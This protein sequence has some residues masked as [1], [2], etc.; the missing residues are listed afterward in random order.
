MEWNLRIFKDRADS[1]RERLTARRALIQAVPKEASGMD[2][3]TWATDGWKV[4]ITAF[5]PT[6]LVRAANS[7]FIDG[8][9]DL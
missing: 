6:K 1:D 4:I 7:A 5:N 8:H 3:P 2:L 9:Q